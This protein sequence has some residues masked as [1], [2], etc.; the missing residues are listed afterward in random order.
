MA[1]GRG[2]AVGVRIIHRILIHYV[3]S[4]VTYYDNSAWSSEV[5][6]EYG[7]VDGRTLDEDGNITSKIRLIMQKEQESINERLN[8]VCLVGVQTPK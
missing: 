3:T 1:I 5:Q 2:L 8:G 6:Y 7:E 4:I